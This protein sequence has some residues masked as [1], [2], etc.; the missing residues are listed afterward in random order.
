MAR[1]PRF[2]LP[3]VPQ[4][5]VQRGN[6]RLPC[7]LDGEDR[8]R[9]L[10]CLRQALLRFDCKLHA[11]VLMSNHVHLLLTPVE[12]GSVSRLMHTFARNYVGSFNGRHGRTGTL[13]EG[14]YKACLVDSGSYFLA[15][16]RYIELNPVRAWMVAQPGDYSWS[17]YGANADGRADSLL[18]AHAEYLALGADPAIRAEAYRTLFAE[19]LPDALVSEIRG[20]LQQQK[21]LGTDRFRAWVE[22]RTGRFAAARPVGRPTQPSN[23]P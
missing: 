20:Y 9:Y 7:F 12:A 6:N 10:Q 22:S 11:Y 18:T 3:G 2:E 1:L 14:R 21:A 17:S 4:H 23:C 13:W 16:S 8:Q 19:A 5:V 15:C